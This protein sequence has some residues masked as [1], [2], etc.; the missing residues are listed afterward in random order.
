MT[1]QPPHS[2]L[3]PLGA[4]LPDHPELLDSLVYQ[5]NGLVVVFVALALIWGLLEIVGLFFRHQGK[6]VL[7][8]PPAVASAG[9]SARVAGEIPPELVAAIGAAVHVSLGAEHR[10]AAIIPVEAPVHD[11]ALEGRRQIHSARKVR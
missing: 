2:L 4:A 10:I 1:P 7:A 6:E 5:L 8:P 9:P 11:W 3:P